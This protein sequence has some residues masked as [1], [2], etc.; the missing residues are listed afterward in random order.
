M[1]LVARAVTVVIGF[2]GVLCAAGPAHADALSKP[3]SPEARNHL[4]LGNRLYGVRSF[5]EAAGEYKAGALIEPAP[6]FDYNLGQCY[7]QLGKYQEALWHYERF[8]TRGNPQG[9]LLDAVN[10]F[11][12]QMSAELDKKKAEARTQPASVALASA[13]VSDAGPRMS[14]RRKWAI[15]I[16]SGGG[17]LVGIGVVLGLR[18]RHLQQDADD[19]CPMVSC[20]RAEEANAL[21]ERGQDSAL[22]ANLAMGIGAAALLWFTSP[23]TE[24][25]RVALAPQITRTYAGLHAGVRF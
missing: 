10:H 23:S 8:R 3:T 12:T 21:I 9:E 25:G 22:Y 2:L 1:R 17:A 6:V 19:L 14:P 4:A 5:E 20:G 24:P 7:R 18:A 16:G 15:G 11:I 13:T